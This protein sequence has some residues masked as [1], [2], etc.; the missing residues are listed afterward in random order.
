MSVQPVKL[1]DVNAESMRSWHLSPLKEYNG[2]GMSWVKTAPRGRAPQ[3]V[4]DG[5]HRFPFTFDVGK[6]KEIVRGEMNRLSGVMSISAEEADK[7]GAFD[8]FADWAHDSNKAEWWG[9]AYPRRGFHLNEVVKRTFRKDRESKDP[10]NPYK[11]DENGRPVEDMSLRFKAAY[12]FPSDARFRLAGVWDDEAGQVIEASAF[13]RTVNRKTGQVVPGS[14]RELSVSPPEWNETRFFLVDEETGDTWDKTVAVD[15]RGNPLTCAK[16]GRPVY[17]FFGPEDVTNGS[18]VTKLVLEVNALYFSGGTGR[19]VSFKAREVHFKPRK[20]ASA[21]GGGGDAK[22]DGASYGAS[23]PPPPSAAAKTAAA[24]AAAQRHE[25]EDEDQDGEEEA[26]DDQEVA[27]AGAGGGRGRGKKRT[28]GAGNVA[29]G[30]KR[31]IGA[32]PITAT[33][34]DEP[35]E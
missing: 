14:E 1:F 9:A 15:S 11:L 8:D 35:E 33:I 19:G 32:P 7:L 22:Y 6:D 30:R 26:K 2:T 12:R 25:D 31:G 16:T 3:L 13:Q 28:R 21:S 27:A 29:S 18:T 20:V 17:R 5:D 4:I 23:A 24:I 34:P 10:K